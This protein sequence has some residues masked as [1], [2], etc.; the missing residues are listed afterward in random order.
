MKAQNLCDAGKAVQ[1]KVHSNAGLPQKTRKISNKEPNL[2]LKR[3]RKRTNKTYIQ[4]KEGDNKD[5]RGD[6]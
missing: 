2:S 5:Q 6:K 4:Q 3:I 1:R